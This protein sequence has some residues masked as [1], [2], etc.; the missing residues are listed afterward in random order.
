MLSPA[1]KNSQQGYLDATKHESYYQI[2][3][4][5]LGFQELNLGFDFNFREL[6]DSLIVV[7]SIDN[8]LSWSLAGAYPALMDYSEMS[9]VKLE[10]PELT[11]KAKVLVSFYW[12]I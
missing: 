4:S 12:P 5:S 6:A 2:E 9:S 8:A 11:N 1:G 3:W 10:L 7:Y